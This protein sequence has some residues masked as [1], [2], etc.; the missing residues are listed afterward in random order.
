MRSIEIPKQSPCCVG[1]CFVAKSKNTP[2]NDIIL[3]PKYSFNF[4]NSKFSSTG[5]VR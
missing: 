5:L 2:R 1:D 3:Y 4:F